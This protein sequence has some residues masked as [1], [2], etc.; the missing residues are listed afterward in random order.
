MSHSWCQLSQFVELARSGAGILVSLGVHVH[1]E[2]FGDFMV[3]L[4]DIPS[5]VG[6]RRIPYWELK[7]RLTQ[8]VVHSYH[9]QA[10]SVRLIPVFSY[11]HLGLLYLKFIC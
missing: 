10:F 8:P 9:E 1:P 5:Y 2:S 11:A 6:R 7:T 4:R 3:G